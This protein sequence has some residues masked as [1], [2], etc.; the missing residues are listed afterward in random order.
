MMALFN[1]T[2]TSS[3]IRL[4][5]QMCSKK[6]TPLHTFI[7]FSCVLLCS[8]EMFTALPMYNDQYCDFGRHIG[9]GVADNRKKRIEFIFCLQHNS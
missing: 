3:N 2:E 5:Y 4:Q 1:N 7:G 8:V 9:Y 6:K